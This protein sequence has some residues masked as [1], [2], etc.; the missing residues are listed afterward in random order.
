MKL[1]DVLKTYFNT[2][3]NIIDNLPGVGDDKEM[4]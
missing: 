2:N 3:K 4:K 1:F